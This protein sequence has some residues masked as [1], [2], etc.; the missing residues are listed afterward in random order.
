MR[1]YKIAITGKIGSGKSSVSD[2]L[3]EAGHPVL[4][5]DKIVRAIYQSDRLFHRFLT[6]NILHNQI[7]SFTTLRQVI[8]DKIKENPL[9]L[10]KI[11]GYLYPIL[12]K[13]RILFE[14]IVALENTNLI[15]FEIPLLFEKNMDCNFD[16]IIC[17]MSEQAVRKARVLTR[18]NFSSEKFDSLNALQAHEET[19]KLKSDYI[20]FNNDS[21]QNLKQQ[22]LMILNDLKA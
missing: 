18:K 21:L 20:L 16:K 14:Q 9:I 5:S 6:E 1:K 15:F 22:T 17:V 13:M 3:R 8:S 2:F 7:K 10:S 19:Q 4:D 12:Q 11:E